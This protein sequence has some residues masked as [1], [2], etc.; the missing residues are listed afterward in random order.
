[1]KSLFEV[2]ELGSWLLG[3]ALGY[4]KKSVS[5]EIAQALNG[6]RVSHQEGV[7]AAVNAAKGTYADNTSVH[8]LLF[9][10]PKKPQDCKENLDAEMKKKLQH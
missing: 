4:W 3:K 5:E 8:E 10:K 6:F 7:A 1:M 9:S 2:G